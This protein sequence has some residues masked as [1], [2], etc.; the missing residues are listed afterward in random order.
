MSAFQVY[1]I[2]LKQKMFFQI[3]VDQSRRHECDFQGIDKLFFQVPYEV[4]SSL[5]RQDHQI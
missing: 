3:G 4:E 5:P 1:V 2:N